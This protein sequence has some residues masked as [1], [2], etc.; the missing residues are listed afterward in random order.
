MWCELGRRLE[1]AREHRGFGQC[2]IADVLVEIEIRRRLYAERA[3][4]HIGSVEIELE[5]LAFGEVEFEPHREIS[6]L[7]LTL[8]RALV[9][10]KQV[11]RKLLGNRRATLHD[12]CRPRIHGQRAHRTDDVDA[13]MLVEAPVFGGEDRLD[14]ML[15]K[16]IERNGI[17]VL[18]AA[19]IPLRSISFPSI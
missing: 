3:A 14:Q 12:G 8:K 7:D 15:G 18:D 4:T 13:P 16:L 17:V 1:Q 5:D 9:R 2:H 11:F 19:A 10:E 6:F